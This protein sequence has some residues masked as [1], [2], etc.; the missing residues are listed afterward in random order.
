M[1]FSVLYICT[2]LNFSP[3]VFVCEQPKKITI[4]KFHVIP[5]RI[6]IFNIFYFIGLRVNYFLLVKIPGIDKICKIFR[7]ISQ[8]EIAGIKPQRVDVNTATASI[9]AYQC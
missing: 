8:C 6:L 1:L 5:L 3:H 4:F 9:F 2:I 7:K